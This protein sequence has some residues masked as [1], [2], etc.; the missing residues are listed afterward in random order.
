MVYWILYLGF[1]VLIKK[2]DSL[3]L[4][5]PVIVHS[6]HGSGVATLLPP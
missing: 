5:F 2:L 3:V 1:Q 4:G 6:Q